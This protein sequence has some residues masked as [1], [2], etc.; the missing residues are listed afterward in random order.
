MYGAQWA[1]DDGMEGD[2]SQRFLAAISSANAAD[3]VE[4]EKSTLRV[5]PML[6][7]RRSFYR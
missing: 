1:R 2:A 6:R 3:P 4:T 7:L 5:E